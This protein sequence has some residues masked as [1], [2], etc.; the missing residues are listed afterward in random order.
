MAI[1]SRT[2]NSGS[3]KISRFPLSGLPGANAF[4]LS[5]DLQTLENWGQTQAAADNNFKM[6]AG[7]N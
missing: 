3:I 6:S 1:E 2:T 7:V 5:A 4:P